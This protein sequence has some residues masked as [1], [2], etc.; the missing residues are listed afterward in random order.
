MTEDIIDKWNTI[1]SK[2]SIIYHA[3]DFA[4]C[5]LEKIKE[6]ISRLNGQLHLVLG[7]HDRYSLKQ[8]KEAGFKSTSRIKEIKV[9]KQKIVMCH[10]AMRV[11]NKSYKGSWMIY[12]HS[13]GR[14][15]S[16]PNSFDV[17]MDVNNYTPISIDEVRTKI[18]S[19]NMFNKRN[20]NENKLDS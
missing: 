2:S 14:L 10:Y 17:G 18:V 12:G 11:W 15:E 8:Y 13:H 3:G 7:N 9:N 5:S 19:T 4:F 16:I 1:C 6:L 20:Y